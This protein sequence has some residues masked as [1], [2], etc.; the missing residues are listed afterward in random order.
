MQFSKNEV[1]DHLR[2]NRQAHKKAYRRARDTW[3]NSV[4]DRYEGLLSQFDGGVYK[5]AANPL[6][7]RPRPKHHLRDYD[8]AIA[9]VEQAEANQRGTIHLSERDHKQYVLDQWDW[10]TSDRAVADDFKFVVA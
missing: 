9:R 4:V 6:N 3:R 7:V 5:N 8:A 2:D 1:L 10:A